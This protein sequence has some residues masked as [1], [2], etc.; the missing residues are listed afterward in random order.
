MIK[1]AILY[2]LYF[3]T[4]LI[5]LILICLLT[6]IYQIKKFIFKEKEN[7]KIQTMNEYRKQF[8]QALIN[9]YKN[10]GAL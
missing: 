3:V 7:K 8:Y 1:N 5:M 10:K 6:P 4:C 9:E 2:A